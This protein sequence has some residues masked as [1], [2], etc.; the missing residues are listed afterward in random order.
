MKHVVIAGK[1]SPRGSELHSW[2]SVTAGAGVPMGALFNAIDGNLA[3]GR[4]FYNLRDD[5]PDFA[6][7]VLGT[8]DA[9][10]NEGIKP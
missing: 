2:G 3:G 6:P 9:R 5:A 7:M 8:Y 10:I 1:L 4:D